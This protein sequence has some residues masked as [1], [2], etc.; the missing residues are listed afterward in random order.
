MV[1]GLIDK[2][3]VFLFVFALRSL[4]RVHY[5]AVVLF[6][7]SSLAVIP[8]LLVSV[9]NGVIVVIL[10]SSFVG[11]VVKQAGR[12][13]LCR[14]TTVS[15]NSVVM[16]SRAGNSS[17]MGIAILWEWME[18]AKPTFSTRCKSEDILIL[19]SKM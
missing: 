2:M 18:L 12:G 4:F 14:F 7:A 16:A 13:D 9:G 11:V 1:G 17:S 5:P 6:M 19:Y 10:T 3:I 15:M 8:F